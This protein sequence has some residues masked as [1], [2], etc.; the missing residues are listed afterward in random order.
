M[1][2]WNG[3]EICNLYTFGVKYTILRN[4]LFPINGIQYKIQ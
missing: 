1:S 2:L 3:I 4:D